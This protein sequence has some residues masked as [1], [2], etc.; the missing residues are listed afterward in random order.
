[1]NLSQA[2]AT[3]G[4]QGELFVGRFCAGMLLYVGSLESAEAPEASRAAEWMRGSAGTPR[5]RATV[6]SSSGRSSGTSAKRLRRSP[7]LS[8]RRSSGELPRSLMLHGRRLR[9]D[10][11]PAVRIRWREGA[12]GRKGRAEFWLPAHLD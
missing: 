11:R 9:L 8:E 7:G 5:M 10:R 6:R 4:R 2:G 3:G 12:S 1:V